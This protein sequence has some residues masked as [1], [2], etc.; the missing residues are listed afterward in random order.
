MLLGLSI[1]KVMLELG[2]KYFVCV[3]YLK[4]NTQPIA[5]FLVAIKGIGNSWCSHFHMGLNP[6][7][8]FLKWR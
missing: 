5:A 6:L 1:C 8:C 7:S 4:G 3:S 2:G